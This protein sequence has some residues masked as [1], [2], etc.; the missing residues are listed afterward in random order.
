MNFKRKLYK[1]M[2]GSFYTYDGY[3][4]SWE[5]NGILTYEGMTFPN[6]EAFEDWVDIQWDLKRTA[7]QQSIE[8]AADKS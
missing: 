1:I 7:L 6:M 5:D 8:R 3:R 2:E 4:A